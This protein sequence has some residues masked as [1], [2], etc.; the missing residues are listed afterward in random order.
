MESLQA[1][2]E[3]IAYI[4]AHLM[5]EIDPEAVARRAGCTYYT[6]STMFAYLAGFT[7]SDYVRR[8]RL[9]RA[10]A[11]LRAPGAR[12]LDVALECGYQSPTAFARAFAVQHGISPREAMREGA[13][14][15]SF[16]AVS[17]QMTIKGAEKME[18]RIEKKQAMRVIGRRWRVSTVGGENFRTIPQ[19]WDGEMADGAW[20]KYE[21]FSGAVVGACAGFGEMEFDYWI[22]KISE[23][24]MP[25][26][27]EALD[28]A[29]AQWA[30]FPCTMETLQQVTQR[31]FSQWLPGSG[32]ELEPLPDLELYLEDGCEI[33]MPIRQKM[34]EKAEK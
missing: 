26:G 21:A 3:A 20:E 2:N 22:G 31:I 32:Y 34:G 24:A 13:K 25:E 7:L 19:I 28:I 4:E 16:P 5:E 18:Y 15:T 27:M 12:V 11:M 33:W 29:A 14:L 10:A 6:F 1:F 9:T 23:D 8:R 30:I 17:F